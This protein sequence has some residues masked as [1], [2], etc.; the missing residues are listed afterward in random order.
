[1]VILLFFQFTIGFASFDFEFSKNSRFE[2][3]L[4]NFFGAYPPSSSTTPHRLCYNYE[5][6]R[7]ELYLSD[8]IIF[9]EIEVKY[10]ANKYE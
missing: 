1:M 6:V 5:I 7:G 9:Y 2:K 8:L 4:N 10:I 3:S